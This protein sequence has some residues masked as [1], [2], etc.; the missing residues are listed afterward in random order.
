MLS[1]PLLHKV[2]YGLMTKLFQK[3]LGGLRKLGTKIVYADFGRIIISTNKH[4]SIVL[5]YCNI[6]FVLLFFT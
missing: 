3:L 1:D 2:I 4:V 5:L 6:F